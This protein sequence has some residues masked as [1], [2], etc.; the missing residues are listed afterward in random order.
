ML[1][2][3][4]KAFKDQSDGLLSKT[5]PDQLGKIG[6]AMWRKIIPVLN[7]QRGIKK[8]DSNLAELYC[9]SYET[10]RKAYQHLQDKG[11]V[12]EIYKTS[13]SPVDGSIVAKDFQGYKKNPSYQIYSDALSN[14][15]RVGAQLGLSPKARSEFMDLKVADKNKKSAAE[16][17][18]E[19]L[20]K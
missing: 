3:V 7:E 1:K 16:S 5:P 11:L 12:Q 4:K 10:Y 2:I 13:L 15:T 18:K 6:A 17:L 9:S 8:I 20:G 19:F 14:L